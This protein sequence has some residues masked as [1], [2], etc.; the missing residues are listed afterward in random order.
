MLEV[1]NFTREDGNS[2]MVSLKR[3]PSIQMESKAFATSKKTAPVSQ[4][5]SKISFDSFNQSG[6]LDSRAEPGSEPE[7]LVPEKASRVDLCHY[8]GKQDLF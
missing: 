6:Q 7:L 2:R 1:I 8:P 3:R 5:L 4:L